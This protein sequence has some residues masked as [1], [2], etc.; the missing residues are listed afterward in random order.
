MTPSRESR[1]RLNALSNR[2]FLRA[3]K[4]FWLS[5]PAADPAQGA[6]LEEFCAWLRET[7]G[8]EGATVCPR[9][10]RSA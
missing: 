1:N 6:L 5:E 10:F 2:D 3:T 4:S 9:R 7:R 8:E